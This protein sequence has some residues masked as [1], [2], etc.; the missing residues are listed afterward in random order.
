MMQKYMDPRES[1]FGVT[2]YMDP[3][4][5][6]FGGGIAGGHAHGGGG[7]AGGRY[8]GR[9]GGFV[10]GVVDD[11][12]VPVVLVDDFGASLT[13]HSPGVSLSAAQAAQTQALGQLI[14]AHV[15]AGGSGNIADMDPA[16]VQAAMDAATAAAAAG[17]PLTNTFWHRL[18][19]ALHLKKA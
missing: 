16:T 6:D 1:D 15:A 5:P 10:Y 9:G 7:R 14:S 4:T 3:T 19:V 8:Y 13:M 12:T 18:L 2:K 17:T 11:D